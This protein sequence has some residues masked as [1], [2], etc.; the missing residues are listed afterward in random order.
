LVEIKIHNG[1]CYSRQLIYETNLSLMEL[2]IK[3]F[4]LGLSS[5]D[6]IIAD[7]AEPHSINKLR[8]G[9]Q[10]SELPEGYA[11]KYQQL[12]NGFYC[13]SASKGPGSIQAGINRVNEYEN[14]L[15]DDSSD[16]WHEYVNY[17]WAKD[18][19]GNPTDEPLDDFNHLFDA[20]RYILMAKGK[21]Y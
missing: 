20:H 7:S 19:N 9:W 8:N 5:N 12:V 2:G 18:K 14:Y 21:L 17:T 4:Q 13:M 16:W 10:R 15:T 1:K 11:D 3:L 6:L